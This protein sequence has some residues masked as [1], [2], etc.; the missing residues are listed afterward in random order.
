V[1]SSPIV[2]KIFF[3]CVN[4]SNLRIPHSLSNKFWREDP[5]IFATEAL[6]VNLGYLARAAA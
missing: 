4:L 3:S 5:L 6:T 2:V 1:G